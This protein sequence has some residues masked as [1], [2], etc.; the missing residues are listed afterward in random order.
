MTRILSL[1]GILLALAGS[2]PDALAQKKNKGL[3]GGV[4]ASPEEYLQIQNV[5]EL[6]GKLAYSDDKALTLRFEMQ[7]MEPNPAF[8]PAAFPKGGGTAGTDIQRKYN[9]I[10]RRQIELARAKNPL[11]RQRKLLQLQRDMQALQLAIAKAAKGPATAKMP[12]DGPFRVVTETKDFDLDIA[13]KLVVRW[14]NP[15][16]EYDDKGNPKTYTK[17]ELTKMRGP[18][19]KLP[20]YMGKPDDLIAGQTVKLFLT[21]PPKDSKTAKRPKLDEDEGIGNVPRPTVQMILIVEEGGLGLG[22]VPAKKKG[23]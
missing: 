5:K 14:L 15:P 20:G 2:A 17:E 12:K 16:F 23:K 1:C 21:P 7:R 11:D 3:K 19:P 10:Q 8:K 18:D 6:V 9:D 22:L 4:K 13:D